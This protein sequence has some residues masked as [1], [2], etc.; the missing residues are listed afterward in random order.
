MAIRRRRKGNMLSSLLM[1]SA[2]EIAL[3]SF[4]LVVGIILIV[5]GGDWFVDAA[6]WIAEISGLSPL[7]VGATVVSV[8]TTL[9]ELIVSIIATSRGSMEIAVGNAVG[10]VVANLGLIMAISLFFMP[11]KVERKQYSFKSIVLVVAVL[12]LLLIGWFGGMQEG[13]HVLTVARKI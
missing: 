6:S 8:A 10:S 7:L 1:G 2:G 13:S 3:S 11:G 4:L 5:K 9:P 12:N